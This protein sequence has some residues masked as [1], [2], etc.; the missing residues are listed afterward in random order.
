M[1]AAV[2]SRLRGND[3]F[4]GRKALHPPRFYNAEL[5]LRIPHE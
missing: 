3:G 2:D 1:S 4:A 5:I